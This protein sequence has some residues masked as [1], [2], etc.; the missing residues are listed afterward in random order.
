M[1]ALSDL[2]MIDISAL[3]STAT[4]AHHETVA[5]IGAACRDIGFFYVSGH[6]IPIDT[7]Q[8][9]FKEAR[10]FFAQD[11]A[12]KQALSIEKSRHNRGYVAHQAEQL[13]PA[14]PADLKEAFNI[15]LELAADDPD[16]LADVPFRGPQPVAGALFLAGVIR[17][18]IIMTVC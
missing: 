18:S 2:P 3:G 14:R 7:L 15:G 10:C 4:R 9:M 12:A 5:A 6:G 11:V 13:E 16:L 8:N 1:D 17:C